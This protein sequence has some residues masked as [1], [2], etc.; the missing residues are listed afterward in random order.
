MLETNSSIGRLIL[1]QNQI[2]F[3]GMQTWGPALKKNSSLFSI[4]LRGNLL[5]DH[6][7]EILASS[8]VENTTLAELELGNNFEI[9]NAGAFEFAKA[10]PYMK[11]LH[12]LKMQY[13]KMNTKGYEHLARALLKNRTITELNVANILTKAQPPI[14][15]S[16][17]NFNVV[18]GL[19]D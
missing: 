9:S 12:S 8:L 17:I 18:S 3:P 13:T 7:A 15:D 10:I 11:G 14:I 1:R 2:A 16:L 6:C 5:T 19:L 4:D